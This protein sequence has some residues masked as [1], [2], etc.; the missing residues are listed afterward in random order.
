MARNSDDVAYLDEVTVV[1]RNERPDRGEIE[2]HKND[3]DDYLVRPT[4]PNPKPK[5]TTEPKQ[6]IEP[7]ER[8]DK[9]YAGFPTGKGFYLVLHEYKENII[10]H[11]N[12]EFVHNAKR[13]GWFGANIDKFTLGDIKGGIRHEY[14]TSQDRIRNNKNKHSYKVIEVSERDYYHALI[15]SQK[16]AQDAKNKKGDYDLIG[17]AHNCV[18][19]VMDTLKK[20][21]IK[22]SEKLVAD[23]MK[24]STLANG[25][26]EVKALK[27]T[28]MEENTAYNKV[29]S[30]NSEFKQFKHIH[31]N[32][33]PRF[34]AEYSGDASFNAVIITGDSKNTTYNADISKHRNMIITDK[35]GQDT[36]NIQN[37]EG[38]LLFRKRGEDLAI[39]DS[40]SQNR[41]TIQ[42]WFKEKEIITETRWRG[43]FRRY[44]ETRIIGEK[45]VTNQYKIEKITLNGTKSLS[46]DKVDKLVEAMAMFNDNGRFNIPESIGPGMPNPEII[47]RYQYIQNAWEEIK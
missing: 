41:I 34:I 45:D 21:N 39:L 13:D 12:I 30:D 9:V 20:A 10:G 23:F 17:K 22:N 28:G 19:F 3:K 43:G 37:V 33:I 46:Y 36:L 35:G 6:P 4:K 5:P 27:A 11:T 29:F 47:I 7:P 1:G 38:M 2:L 25:Y 42:D 18:D 32:D 40:K 44:Y 15:Y 8:I 16:L 31:H 26:A 14:S 24:G